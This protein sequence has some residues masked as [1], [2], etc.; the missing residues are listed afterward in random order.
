ML[1]L[2]IVLFILACH[3]DNR[4]LGYVHGLSL[5]N[6][7][8]VIAWDNFLYLDKCVCVQDTYLNFLCLPD[9]YSNMAPKKARGRKP[10]KSPKKAS[11]VVPAQP[12]VVESY[13]VDTVEEE[14]DTVETQE[15]D[16][17][18]VKTDVHHQKLTVPP[19]AKEQDIVQ[20]AEAQAD[21]SS[22]GGSL[23]SLTEAPLKR[24]Y[25]KSDL[26]LEQEGELL[27][28]YRD[29]TCLYDKTDR[30]SHNTK[31]KDLLKREQAEKMGITGTFHTCNNH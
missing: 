9:Q 7:C 18:E 5:D 14:S 3:T 11:T 6:G 28:W 24:D 16:V 1:S 21:L 15:Q 4:P 10:G 19:P 30:Q 2:W 25:V 13:L 31:Y 29:H 23:P 20:H 17:S 26:S 12:V 27:D 8:G 22:S